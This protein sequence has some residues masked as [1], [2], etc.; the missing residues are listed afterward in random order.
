MHSIEDIKSQGWRSVTDLHFAQPLEAIA[1]AVAEVPLVGQ[2]VPV[3]F[4]Q[5]QGRWRVMGVFAPGDGRNRFVEPVRGHWRGHCVPALLRAYPFMLRRDGGG[6]NGSDPNSSAQ[7]RLALWPGARSEPLGPGVQLYA[8]DGKPTERVQQTL[9]FLTAVHAGIDQ[10][11]AVLGMLQTAGVLV[12]WQVAGVAG[13]V[14]LA[15]VELRVLDEQKFK[16][17][18][19][20]ALLQLRDMDALGWLYAHLHSLHFAK[21]FLEEPPLAGALDAQAVLFAAAAAGVAGPVHAPGAS[22]TSDASR[23]LADFAGGLEW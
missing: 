10:A 23:A 14:A 3:A 21:A 18:D 5:A 22:N 12:P 1:L 20:A 4:H 15:G 2:S 11:H 13:P 6:D 9:S 8:V 19:P 16:A 7:G 17:L